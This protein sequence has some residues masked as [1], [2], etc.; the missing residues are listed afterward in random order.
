[1]L[2]SI[3]IRTRLI[4]LVGCPLLILLATSVASLR[5]IAEQHEVMAS[6]ATAGWLATL[7][8]NN[9]S[10]VVWPHHGVSPAN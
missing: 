1:M 4:L 3:S 10:A 7:W 5:V 9:W 8:W 2:R 6:T